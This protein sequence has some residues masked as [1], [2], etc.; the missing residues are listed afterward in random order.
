M[1]D[2]LSWRRA[3]CGRAIAVI[4][5]L[6]RTKGVGRASDADAMDAVGFMVSGSKKKR[7]HKDP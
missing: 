4:S 6:T 5:R 7:T 3:L 1:R 2:R